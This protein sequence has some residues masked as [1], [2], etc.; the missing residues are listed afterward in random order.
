[1]DK[2]VMH[3]VRLKWALYENPAKCY[4]LVGSIMNALVG[5]VYFISF[6]C[7]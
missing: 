5:Y 6:K 7:M 4:A 3:A 2:L 1:M